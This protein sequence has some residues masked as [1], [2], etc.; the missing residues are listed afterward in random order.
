MKITVM[1]FNQFLKVSEWG[2]GEDERE[3]DTSVKGGRQV[4]SSLGM[5]HELILYQA[6]A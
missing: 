5:S 2:V 1:Q 6:S 4:E 3:T